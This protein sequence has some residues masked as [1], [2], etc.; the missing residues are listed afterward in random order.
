MGPATT[1]TTTTALFQLILLPKQA[2]A[3]QLQPE[4]IPSQLSAQ[5]PRNKQL[6][7]HRRSSELSRN[8]PARNQ[9]I[10]EHPNAQ[11]D[12][13][14]LIAH[15]HLQ[16]QR[17]L[18]TSTSDLPEREPSQGWVINYSPIIRCDWASLA[19][20]HNPITIANFCAPIQSYSNHNHFWNET[21]YMIDSS[22]RQSP[23]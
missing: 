21:K 6:L 14:G 16:L 10:P 17:P 11:L 4:P 12:P 9:S 5:L 3:I 18:H 22:V 1:T 23:D 19:I 8:A 15:K 7:Q 13:L 20:N 2:A